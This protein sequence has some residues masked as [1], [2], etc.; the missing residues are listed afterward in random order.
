M[1][2][3]DKI[4]ESAFS[5]YVLEVAW[6]YVKLGQTDMAQ[7]YL[8]EVKALLDHQSVPPSRLYSVYY[9]V[10]MELFRV[11]VACVHEA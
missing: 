6:L 2:R 8:D 5:R 7:E 10:S 11:G 3:R 9:R 4:G 1:M